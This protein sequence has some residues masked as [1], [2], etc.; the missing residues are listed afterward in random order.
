MKPRLFLS[1]V[2]L[3]LAL[4][5]F[6][7]HGQG[8]PPGPGPGSQGPGPGDIHRSLNALESELVAILNRKEEI[9]NATEQRNTQLAQLGIDRTKADAKD[10]DRI[11]RQIETLNTQARAASVELSRLDLTSERI[12]VE[13]DR[14]MRFDSHLSGGQGGQGG[15]RAPAI[16]SINVVKTDRKGPTRITGQGV[17]FQDTTIYEVIFADGSRQRVESTTFVPQ[18][19]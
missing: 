2:L 16:R 9:I 4:S 19:N 6:P 5:W 15:G 8:R 7:A 13:I 1:L 11:T 3:P 14:L 12:R 18:R 17:G 10:R